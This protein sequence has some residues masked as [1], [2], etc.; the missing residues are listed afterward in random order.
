MRSGLA[1]AAAILSVVGLSQ[2]QLQVRESYDY[3]ICGGGTAGL[4]VAAR[5]SELNATVL[6]VEVGGDAADAVD[7]EYS[8]TLYNTTL[9]LWT[10]R[11]LG[12]SS[13]VNG[14]IYLRAE[15]QQINDWEKAGNPGWNWENLWP[16]YL[17]SETFVPPT[18]EQSYGG[19]NYS[20]AYHGFDGPVNTGWLSLLVDEP[21]FLDMLQASGNAVGLPTI[22]DPNGGSM[23]GTSTWPRT[24][25]VINDTTIREDSATAYIDPIAATRTNLDVLTNTTALRIIWAEGQTGNLTASGVEIATVG[26]NSTKVVVK[27][28]QE[29]ILSAGAYRSASILE[30]SGV[31]NPAIL[32]PL[33]IETV[34]D[35]PG[36]GEHL[37]DQ[38][39]NTLSWSLNTARN[40]STGYTGYVVY[41]NATDLFG[42]NTSAVAAEL[43][44]ALPDYAASI[45]ASNNGAA[46]AE[47]IEAILTIQY[48]S[49]FES[50][51]ST[52]EML[53]QLYFQAPNVEHQWWTTTPFS[54]GNVHIN[55]ATPPTDGSIPVEIVNRFWALEFDIKTYVAAAKFLR[56][57]YATAPLLGSAVLE[58]TDPG[59]ETVPE[60]ASDDVWF[61]WIKTGYSTTWHPV[62]T[63]PMLPKEAGGVVDPELFVYG[64]TNVRVVDAGI[65]PFQVSGHPSSTVYAVAERAADIIK[66]AFPGS[67]NITASARRRDVADES[68]HLARAGL[69]ARRVKL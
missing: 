62:G 58:E 28:T 6:V 56:K 55:T 52:T 15:A 10:G 29:V 43:L 68:I 1:Y 37:I 59:L 44:A 42:T 25:Q 60:D 20:A 19:A 4:A 38:P 46:S 18:A 21:D 39:E 48:E 26:T 47:A 32:T 16:Y 22:Q 57:L 51:I 5:L 66:T 35:L 50:Q 36:V 23:R 67:A 34:L 63:T 31:G 27:A 8:Q 64:T 7:W 61:D 3:V 69:R 45:A 12:G 14:E 11:G 24:I 65:F 54:Q 17:K 53:A 9:S 41:P 40:W 13:S 30:F 33:G 49:I 2:Q